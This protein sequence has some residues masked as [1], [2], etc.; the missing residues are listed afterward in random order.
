MVGICWLCAGVQGR[1]V[2]TG[3]SKLTR[4]QDTLLLIMHVKSPELVQEGLM[5]IVKMATR[6]NYLSVLWLRGETVQD[7][8]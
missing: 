1:Y 2:H 6:T 7:P 4:Q 5:Q 3:R 8:V